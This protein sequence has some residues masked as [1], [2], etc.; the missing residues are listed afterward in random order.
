MT[1]YDKAVFTTYQHKG[2]DL[3][4][5]KQGDY[6]MFIKINM[7][8]YDGIEAIQR[9]VADKRFSDCQAGKYRVYQEDLMGFCLEIL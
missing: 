8:K 2:V 6:Q 1:I 4:G 3:S 7:L 9:I 5:L